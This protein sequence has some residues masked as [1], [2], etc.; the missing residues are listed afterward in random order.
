MSAEPLKI[1]VVEDDPSHAAAICR[2]FKVADHSVHIKGKKRRV[3]T[4]LF[5][6][7]EYLKL[8]CRLGP[9]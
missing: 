4:R 9:S 8:H 5:F 2:A 1:L 7:P 6:M 3:N